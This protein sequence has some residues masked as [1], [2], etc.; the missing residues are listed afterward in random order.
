MLTLLNR[1]LILLLCLPVLTSLPARAGEREKRRDDTL[2]QVST[3]DA[4]IEGAYSGRVRFRT[5]ERRGDFGPGTFNRPDGEMVA[6]G[7]EY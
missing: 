2:F 1:L 5:L 6:L 7:G 4:L 3:L